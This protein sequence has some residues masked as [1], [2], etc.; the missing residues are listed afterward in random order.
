MIRSICGIEQRG[1]VALRAAAFWSANPVAYATGKDMSPFG[2]KEMSPL[3]FMEICP[4]GFKDTSPSSMNVQEMV[5][6]AHGTVKY[7]CYSSR[8]LILIEAE[9]WAEAVGGPG[10][11]E[12][13]VDG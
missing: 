13:H 3:G 10:T 9:W 6:V 1:C 5:C 11:G 12:A 2:L 8:A 4:F 7:C